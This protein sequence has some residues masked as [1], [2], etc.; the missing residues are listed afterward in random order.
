MCLDQ[1]QINRQ[2]G[3]P[4]QRFRSVSV[5]KKVLDALQLLR[6]VGA[7]FR[8][9]LLKPFCLLLEDRQPHRDVKPIQQVLAE[10]MKVLLH[11]SDVFAPVGHEYHL[12]V[13]LHPL[14]FHQLP[15]PPARLLVIGLHEAKA[16]RRG[17]LGCILAPEGNDALASDYFKT[18][19]F[20]RRSNVA[21][22]DANR[23]RTVRQ[24]LLL[25]IVF[26]AFVLI[27]LPLSAQF[28]FDPLRCRLEVDA[29][30]FMIGG[31]PNR[32]Y[33]RQ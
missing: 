23:D 12:L 29:D 13:F 7:S 16:L 33:F 9:L 30:T 27:E 18:P 6:D 2:A 26:R 31:A 4:L 21:A 28:Q 24:R 17:H 5:P 19:L 15:Q 25:P 11:A 22:I 8:P 20:M 1:A 14:R 32:Q 3:N 10:R